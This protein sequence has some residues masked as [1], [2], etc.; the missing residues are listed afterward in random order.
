MYKHFYVVR[1]GLVKQS[2]IGQ[3]VK[4]L[5][6]MPDEGMAFSTNVVKVSD[7]SMFVKPFEVIVRYGCVRFAI[8]EPIWLA[9]LHCRQT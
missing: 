1:G 4:I 8:Q 3:V 7:F 6:Y 5:N 9:R 2:M